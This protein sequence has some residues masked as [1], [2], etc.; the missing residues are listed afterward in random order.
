MMFLAML[1]C[2][3][4]RLARI[5][6]NNKNIQ[7]ATKTSFLSYFCTPSYTRGC[8]FKLINNGLAKE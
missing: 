3:F 7:G 2:R 1:E 8:P 6:E 4:K 5:T